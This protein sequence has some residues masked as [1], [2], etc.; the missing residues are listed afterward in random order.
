MF[1]FCIMRWF[2]FFLIIH[3][4]FVALVPL[5]FLILGAIAATTGF[6]S[7]LL[8]GCSPLKPPKTNLPGLSRWLLVVAWWSPGVVRPD[9]NQNAERKRRTRQ[10]SAP[11][12]FPLSG[13]PGRPIRPA[14]PLSCSLGVGVRRALFLFWLGGRGRFGRS[15]T[16]WLASRLAG[17]AEL[18]GPKSTFRA[19]LCECLFLGGKWRMAFGCVVRKNLKEGRKEFLVYFSA[20][21]KTWKWMLILTWPR[22]LKVLFATIVK[23]FLNRSVPWAKYRKLRK[24]QILS[25]NFKQ[26]ALLSNFSEH[27]MEVDKENEINSGSHDQPRKNESSSP[28]FPKT[29]MRIRA[30]TAA[31]KEKTTT[32]TP[33]AKMVAMIFCSQRPKKSETTG[34][35]GGR[36]TREKG[37]ERQEKWIFL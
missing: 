11:I 3:S 21:L 34:E 1:Y 33:K 4:S 24:C 23:F 30:L 13:S 2:Q 12:M 32:T 14:R 31:A 8:L 37:R 28:F 22:I 20:I 9:E 6:S 5:F 19:D 17:G 26:Q 36:N 16:G 29:E 18:A 15:V 35:K 7:F 27:V 10:K 25:Y